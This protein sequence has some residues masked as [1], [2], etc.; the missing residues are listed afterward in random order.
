MSGGL[1]TLTSRAT[2]ARHLGEF[3]LTSFRGI[4]EE[5][6]IVE[7]DLHSIGCDCY[8][9]PLALGYSDGGRRSRWG[10]GCRGDSSL[11][12]LLVR[13]SLARRNFYVSLWRFRVSSIRFAV[14]SISLVVVTQ[15]S[16]SLDT[17]H[18]LLPYISVSRHWRRGTR[19]AFLMASLSVHGSHPVR[20]L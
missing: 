1:R 10:R 9:P 6:G 13:E 14:R 16:T 11:S 4:P 8:S 12:S 7:L 20:P 2:S 19:C 15:E 5:D 18:R 3:E 17:C